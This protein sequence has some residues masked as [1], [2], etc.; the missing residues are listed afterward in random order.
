MMFVC[1]QCWRNGQ[2]SEAD[3]NKKYCAAKARHMWV[4]GS[5]PGTRMPVDR[6]RL[7]TWLLFLSL[8]WAKDRRVV[9]VSSNERKKW[10]TVRSLPTKKPIPSQF[11]VRAE[12]FWPLLYLWWHQISRKRSPHVVAFSHFLDL[13]ACDCRQ[14]VSVHWEL[15]VCPQSRREGPLDLH[16][17]KQQWVPSRWDLF[18]F[19]HKS[20][21]LI[22]HAPHSVPDMDQLYEQWLQSQKPGWG[23]EASS[24]LVRENGKQIHMPTD[25][26]EEVVSSP[27]A[28]RHS[29]YCPPQAGNLSSY[30]RLH[31]SI[32]FTRLLI[33]KLT[34]F[35]FSAKNH[36]KAQL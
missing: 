4:L 8:R 9:L 24:N 12:H 35:R 15:H 36:T 32:S 33:F 21:I 31:S 10:T 27:A 11:E 16:E 7:H 23:D 22:C 28:R 14:E 13:H 2:L 18:L 5:V 6:R 25:Y 29:D 17:G 19:N 3:K 20:Q 1:G 30:N 34:E 26:A